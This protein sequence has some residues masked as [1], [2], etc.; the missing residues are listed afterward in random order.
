[1]GGLIMIEGQRDRLHRAIRSLSEHQLV[2]TPDG[3]NYS[4]RDGKT[5]IN[6]SVDS[7]EDSVI[8]LTSASWNP[9]RWTPE[10]RLACRIEAL[11]KSRL[12]TADG[13]AETTLDV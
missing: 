4:I 13:I 7:D 11:I 6:A 3:D 2:V 10:H 12:E 5:V 8:F 9:I 1:M